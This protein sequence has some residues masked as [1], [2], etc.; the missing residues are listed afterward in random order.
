MYLPTDEDAWVDNRFR[1]KFGRNRLVLSGGLLGG[2]VTT[3]VRNIGAAVTRNSIYVRGD[4]ATVNVAAQ[5][6]TSRVALS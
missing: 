6:T 5:Q 4:S 3:T 2:P 1:N